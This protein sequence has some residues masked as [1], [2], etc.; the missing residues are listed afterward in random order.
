VPDIEAAGLSQ[1]LP[2]KSFGFG[3]NFPIEGGGP[4]A[5]NILA[6]W[7]I[8]SAGY[9]DALGLPLREGRAFDAQD[10]RGSERVAIVSESYARR[11]WPN[12]SPIGRRIGWA[13]LDHPM[14]VVGVAADIRLSPAAGI[15]PHV[16][17][18][19]S[20]VEEFQPSELAVR[21]SGAAADARVIDAVRR[22]VWSVD[23]RQPVAGIRT[24][25]SLMW[26]LLG[27]RRFQ[28]ALWAGFAVA[29]ALLALLGVYGVVSCVV[30]Q[31]TREIGIRL[32]LGAPPSSVMWRVLGQGSTIAIAGVVAGGFIAYGT[33]RFI[34]G[35][36]V[37][38]EPR[39]PLVYAA[40]ATATVV[41][42]CA[43]SLLPARRASQVDPLAVLRVD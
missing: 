34:E 38:V 1:A 29:A 24:L 14:T 22:A 28:L 31:G 5:P 12:A 7:R 10:R 39:D 37:G 15:A 4:Q 19:Y 8:V 3:S 30:R 2:L 16:Y 20:Q 36:L 42:A 18:P 11:A 21:A 23:P 9:F 41:A 13:T 33:A 35:F 40:V 6:Y 17:M 32:A 26:Q 25:D 43:A 27:R